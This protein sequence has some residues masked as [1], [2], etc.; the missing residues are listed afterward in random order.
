MKRFMVKLFCAGN[1]TEFV[2]L[3][4]GAV[5]VQLAAWR[6][7]P[8]SR[9]RADRI[10]CS[11]LTSHLS[12]LTSHLSPLT[13]HLSPDTPV[14]AARI[15]IER[16]LAEE[17]GGGGPMVRRDCRRTDLRRTAYGGMCSTRA[18]HFATVGYLPCVAAHGV[19]RR[20]GFDLVMVS[21]ATVGH[22]EHMFCESEPHG[23]VDRAR[24]SEFWRG[25]GSP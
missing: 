18:I 20:R 25:C 3:V 14:P 2:D 23:L 19:P 7:A 4:R 15:R 6:V 21:S 13:S 8:S 17:T 5:L 11:P 12:P 10:C 1:R 24:L 16:R 22:R 9:R